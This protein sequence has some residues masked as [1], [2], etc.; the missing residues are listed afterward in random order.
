MSQADVILRL[1]ASCDQPSATAALDAV[2]AALDTADLA[3]PV[4][5]VS[6]DC[7]GA[8]AEPVSLALQGRGRATCLFAGVDPQDDLDDIVATIRTYLASPRGWIE[9]ARPC[10]RL[11][12]CLRGRVPALEA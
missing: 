11:R 4:A 6:Q 2:R 5:V 9:D 12:F 3:V 8:C 7:M 1:C 10:G